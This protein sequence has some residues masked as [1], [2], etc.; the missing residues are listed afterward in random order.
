[1]QEAGQD[2]SKGNKMVL[3]DFVIFT[4]T[5]S[6]QRRFLKSITYVQVVTAINSHV[7]I[8]ASWQLTDLYTNLPCRYS[9]LKPWQFIRNCSLQL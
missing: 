2:D 4:D 1:M 3:K 6:E 9:L 8:N 7:H 5:F